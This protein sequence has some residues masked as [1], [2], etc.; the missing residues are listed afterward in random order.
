MSGSVRLAKVLHIISALWAMSLAFL[1]F[2]D[3]SLRSVFSSPLP[4]TK[5]IIQ[6][7]VVAI[8]FLQIPLAI[9]SGAMLRTSALDGMMGPAGRKI[10][11]LCCW[12]MGAA[13]FAALA[14]ASWEP[15]LTA[16][17]IGEYE[18]EGALRVP[19]W[20]VRGILVVMG[21]FSAIAY[22]MMFVWDLRGQ[23]VDDTT[24]PPAATDGS[25]AL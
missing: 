7:S 17:R 6:N 5:E 25:P 20:P 2:A 18:G 11:R 19:T 23:L 8:T 16:L 10:L 14:S 24:A 1:I 22:A 4:G 3:V 13:V 12:L 21:A 9:Y 15:F